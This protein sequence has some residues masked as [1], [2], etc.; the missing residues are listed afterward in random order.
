MNIHLR[1]K[2]VTSTVLKCLAIALATFATRSTHAQSDDPM[3]NQPREV[4]FAWLVEALQ[5]VRI[6][7]KS[8]HNQTNDQGFRN[9]K[10]SQIN[11]AFL[12]AVASR[13]E[14]DR[15]GLI[16]FPV[17]VVGVFYQFNSRG[18][19]TPTQK[20][21]ADF[22]TVVIRLAALFTNTSS[23]KVRVEIPPLNQASDYDA[24]Q[25]TRDKIIELIQWY[26]PEC[27]IEGIRKFYEKSIL[28]KNDT[29]EPISVHAQ[30]LTRQ[31]TSAGFQ[32]N[33]LPAQPG[34]GRSMQ[35]LI[36]ARSS[37]QLMDRTEQF[38]HAS[39]IRIWA[40]SDSGAH[41]NEWQSKDL[42]LVPENS[43]LNGERAYYSKSMAS[44]TYVVP[45][46]FSPTIFTERLVT[47]R[48]DTS[49]KLTGNMRIRVRVNG[50][51][52][53]LTVGQFMLDPGQTFTPRREDGL[54][55]RASQI[56]INA[57]GNHLQFSRD[58]IQPR[59]LIDEV[60]GIRAYRAD[61][62]GDFFYAFGS[63]GAD[64]N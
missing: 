39:C 37:R 4:R 38:V 24:V 12:D 15:S 5:Q 6:S 8:G 18:A 47:L 19:D 63:V 31:R 43:Q 42:W 55:V 9:R 16:Q 7:H 13:E 36:P 34:Y 25:L 17:Q 1:A 22:Q 56:Q 64:R 44:Y 41:W 2:A 59:W 51:P 60:N 21:G 3:L 33:W 48:N 23:P 26:L 49:E 32:W 52:T 35:L 54:R 27:D 50:N 30:V 62:I 29:D 10:H 40:E 11:I 28:V 57:I 20:S 58:S 45:D 61:K 46:K 14:G 53:W